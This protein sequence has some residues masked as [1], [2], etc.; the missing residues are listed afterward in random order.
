MDSFIEVE[1]ILNTSTF[2]FEEAQVLW[3]CI[4]KH[5]ET[6]SVNPTLASIIKNAHDLGYHT[7][8]K[9]DSKDWIIS[10]FSIP[11]EVQDAR[12]LVGELRKLQVKREFYATIQQSLD[13]LVNISTSESLSKIVSSVEEPIS[14]FISKLSSVDGEGEFLLKN[15]DIYIDNLFNNPNTVNGFYTGYPKYDDFIGGALEPETM[16]VVMAR[17]KVG[18]SSFALNTAINLAKKNVFSIIADMEMSERKWLNRFLS[19][20]TKIN[21]RKFKYANF[22]EEEKDKISDSYKKIKDYPILYLNVNGK[23]L[24]EANYCVKRLLS[25]KVGKNS[26]GR[27]DCVYIYDYLRVN[28][29]ADV[30]DSIREYQ[31]LGFQAIKLKDFAIASKIPVVTFTQESRAGDVSGS[32]RILWLCD[33]LTQFSKKTDEEIMES[34]NKD[35]NRKMT[36]SET[37]DGPEVEDGTYINYMFDGSTAT[38][39]EGPTNVEL[40]YGKRTI[41]ATDAD[42]ETEF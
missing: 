41:T 23:S 39:K 3:S 13:S 5:Y 21:I 1:G 37:R 42:K 18:K 19:N 11:T 20:M 33:S 6:E 22:T 9:K 31:A 17:P 10:L 29:S 4:V 7:F 8:E 24:E 26:A 34:S 30:S 12:I 15:G 32:D 36:F 2:S 16:H 25:K 35:F 38:I 40:Q 28:D 14:S 27:Y